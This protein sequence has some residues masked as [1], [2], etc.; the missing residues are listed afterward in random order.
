MNLFKIKF[1][2]MIFMIFSCSMYKWR[3]VG[4]GLGQK[5]QNGKSKFIHTT[6]GN[7]RYA[8]THNLIIES[9]EICK[10]FSGS[11]CRAINNLAV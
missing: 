11:F 5:P 9:I 2:E 8:N 1:S 4:V 7:L 3:G 6:N 10:I